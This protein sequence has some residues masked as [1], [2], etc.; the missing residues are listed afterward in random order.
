MESTRSA[1][2]TRIKNT[3]D[4]LSQ[5]IGL[6]FERGLLGRG[7]SFFDITKSYKNISQSQ[8]SNA[9]RTFKLDTEY[10]LSPDSK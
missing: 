4:S 7:E 5:I 6:H 2:L 10:F 3:H 1:L 8:I 9:I